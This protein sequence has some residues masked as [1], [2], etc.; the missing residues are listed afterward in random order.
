MLAAYNFLT[1]TVLK[2]YTVMDTAPYGFEI[3]HTKTDG[4]KC[5][6]IPKSD[7]LINGLDLLELILVHQ[8]E[9]G[10]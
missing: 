1:H 4:S 10:Q 5:R 7:H 2:S 3:N 8:M 9:C 6:V